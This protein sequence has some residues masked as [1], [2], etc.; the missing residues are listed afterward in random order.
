MDKHDDEERRKRKAFLR[1]GTDKPKCIFCSENDWRCLELHH[2][3][4]EAVDPYTVIVCRNHHRKLSD[5]QNDHPMM[6]ETGK[7]LDFLEVVGRFLLG[8]ADMFTQ[9]VK[10]MREF[11]NQLIARAQAETRAAQ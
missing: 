8:L 5:M 6:I 2:V 11:G 4:G 7:A 10:I 9:L 1:L 3:A